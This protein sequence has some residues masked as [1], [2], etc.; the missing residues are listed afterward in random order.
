MRTGKAVRVS[1][2]DGDQELLARLA[3]GGLAG[4]PGRPGT[5]RG[6]GHRGAVRLQPHRLR[7]LR[8]GRT[9]GAG[10]PGRRGGNGHREGRAA[11]GDPGGADQAVGDRRAHLPGIAALDPDG[12]V[13]SWNPGFEEITGYRSADMVGSRGLARLRPGTWP[14]ARSSSTA[15]PTRTPRCCTMWSPPR[16]T[17][18]TRC[19]VRCAAD[20]HAAATGG[21]GACERRSG[22]EVHAELHV[23]PGGV[24]EIGTRN[25]PADDVFFW[26]QGPTRG[27]AKVQ[28]ADWT[29]VYEKHASIP[30]VARFYEQAQAFK[31]LLATAAPDAGQQKDLDFMLN[32]GHLFSLIVYGQLDPRAGRA[33][34]PRRRHRRSDLRLPD[35]RL[36]HL[37]RCAARQAKLDAGPAGLGH[38]R[39]PQAGIRR[40]AL[41]PGLAAGQGLRRRLRD[42]ALTAHT[43]NRRARQPPGFRMSRQPVTVDHD[44]E[45]EVQPHRLGHRLPPGNPLSRNDDVAQRYRL[46]LTRRG[47][48]DGAVVAP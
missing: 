22:A 47:A 44:V 10:R 26:N 6:Q 11:R 45:V 20:R 32:V 7:R 42:A 29:P 12:T 14:G 5:G 30:N 3:R 21:H 35:P 15:G 36:H 18:R 8:A 1:A 33:D 9:G 46:A 2:Q 16:D 41:R 27:A 39:D 43:G 13:S 48:G 28:F 19:S 17:R 23:Q 38:R 31:T 24:P 37:C 4:L 25:D 34:R 40:R